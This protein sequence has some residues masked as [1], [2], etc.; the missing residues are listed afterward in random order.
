[1]LCARDVS[2]GWGQ[3]VR[4]RGSLRRAHESHLFK[5]NKL[6]GFLLRLTVLF[7][8]TSGSSPFALMKINRGFTQRE[9]GP[10]VVLRIRSSYSRPPSAGALSAPVPHYSR[11]ERAAAKLLP[12]SRLPP[13]PANST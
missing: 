4:V 10:H 3:P 13:K 12:H 7:G 9:S 2:E 5:E 1:M 8:L 11:E 6:T